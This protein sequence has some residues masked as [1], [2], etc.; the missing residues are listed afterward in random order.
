MFSTRIKKS[1]SKI[2]DACLICAR[3]SFND[4]RYDVAR[5]LLEKAIKYKKYDLRAFF[6]LAEIYEKEG[7]KQRALE[8]YK[9]IMVIS[10]WKA[11]D[12]NF[13]RASK[14]IF[15]LTNTGYNPLD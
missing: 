11:K 10:E 8:I 1:K 5:I 13:Q 9:E 6:L 15:C 4:G 12:E 14:K 2:F 7:K 3:N